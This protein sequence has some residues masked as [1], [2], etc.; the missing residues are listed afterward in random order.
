MNEAIKKLK[1]R[2]EELAGERISIDD[3]IEVEYEKV[4]KEKGIVPNSLVIVGGR[5]KG[6]YIGIDRTCGGFNPAV[7]RIK[8]D[9]TAHAT[10]IIYCFSLEDIKL[11]EK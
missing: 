2:L 1:A 5:Q 4:L 8:K 9:G 10:A 6:I 3:Q 7:R 11:E